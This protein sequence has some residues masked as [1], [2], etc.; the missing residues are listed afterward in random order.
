MTLSLAF[1]KR[2]RRAAPM[3]E[4]DPVMTVVRVLLPD[5]L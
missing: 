3:P 5:F 2:V 1:S 4:A